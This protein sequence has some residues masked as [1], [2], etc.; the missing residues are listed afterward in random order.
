[1]SKFLQTAAMVVGGVA[2]AAT[3]VGL[4]IGATAAAAAGSAGIGALSISTL[5]EAAGAVATGLSLVASLTA[6]APT[7][8]GNPDQWSANPDAG[9]PICF[10][11]TYNGGQIVYRRAYGTGGKKNIYETIFTV[12]SIGPIGGISKLYVDN[13]LTAVGVDGTVA[14]SD[15]GKMYEVRQRGLCPE[16]SALMPPPITPQGWTYAHKLSGKAATG[17]TFIYDSKGGHTFTSTPA[18]GWA[19]TGVLVYDP[20]KD[21]TYSGGDGPQRIDD[22]TTWSTEG[23]DNPYLV[24]LTWCIGWCQNGKLAAGV[25]LDPAGILIDQFV[26]GANIA[27][28][29]GWKVG[30]VKYTTDDKW[31][32]LTD[33]LQAGGGRPLR[34]GAQ[35]GCVVNAP[36]VSLA[37]VTHADLRGEPSAAG[38]APR[39]SRIN[40]VSPR[41]NAE[42]TQVSNGKTLTQWGL[43]TGT[44]IIVD[45]YVTAD[46]RQR[47]KQIDYPLVQSLAGGSLDQIAQLAR[48]DIENLRE[49]GPISLPLRI[50]WMGYRPGDCITVDL[51]EIGLNDQDV[52]INNRSLDAESTFVTISATSETAAK[53]PFA[54]GQTTTPPSTPELTA[55]DP[56]VDAPGEDEWTVTGSTLSSSSGSVPA[57]EVDGAC[58]NDAATTVIFE[59]RPHVDGQADDVNWEAVS[60]EPP[61]VTRKVITSVSPDTTYDVAVSYRVRGV[62]GSRLI[63]GPVTAGQLTAGNALQQAVLNSWIVEVSAGET[64]VTANADGTVDIAANTRRYPDGHADVACDAGTVTTGLAAG[65]TGMIAYDDPDRLGGAVTYTL[66][67]ND[68]DAHA[69]ATNPGRHYMGYFTIPT[70]GSAGGGG[71]GVGGGYCVVVDTPILTANEGGPG[72]EKIAADLRAGID[73]MWTQHEITMQWGSFPIAAIE[74]VDDQ[75]VYLATI[76]GRTL[77][78]TAEHRVWLDAQWQTLGDIG[79]PDGTASV[80]KITVDGAHTYISNGVLS[81]NAKAIP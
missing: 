31:D 9:I 34:L 55:Y 56:S 8:Q 18:C 50:R 42:Q 63:L 6:H 21:S 25:G 58:E 14:I 47:R 40:A 69:S 54:L 49:F 36:K 68:N 11:Y 13:V 7:T 52:L 41:Y 43:I 4:A 79:T 27:D 20:R 81:H 44:P 72:M 17:V 32:V 30:G 24:G 77:R 70:S 2:L 78:G 16:A 51:P 48:Y 76:R 64:V 26:E 33:I 46:G 37:T 5:A 73:R 12:W 61:S 74:I 22:Q 53:H 35:L 65:D 75:P 59:L 29:N 3:G 80:A 67:T 62:V 23:N 71:G 28:T 57:I 19:G 39:R 45:D 38:A 60:T 10:G 15:R 1:M 66:Y